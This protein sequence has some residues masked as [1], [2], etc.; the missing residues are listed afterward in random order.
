MSWHRTWR[1]KL[2]LDDI[3][4]P[5]V[6]EV[7]VEDVPGIARQTF[8]RLYSLHKVMA[9]SKSRE[10]REAAEALD[11]VLNDLEWMRDEKHV[12][13]VDQFNQWLDDLYDWADSNSV[14]LEV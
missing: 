11:D 10:D 1:Y 8:D 5:F 3:L 2:P 9:T 6:D 4:R 13:D 14:W 12:E 7:T